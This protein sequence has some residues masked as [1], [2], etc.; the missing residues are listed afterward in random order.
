MTR[1]EAQAAVAACKQ[2]RPEDG[3]VARERDGAWE[4][5][6]LPGMGRK[7]TT[8][9]IRPLDSQLDAATLPRLVSM[10]VRAVL[11]DPGFVSALKF[12]S[13]PVVRLTAG[14]SSLAAILPNS[15]LAVLAQDYRADPTLAAHVALGEL[16]AIWLELPG[17][18]GRGAAVLL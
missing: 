18:A 11:V 10:G 9:L 6:R 5:V 15:E 2:E 3:W 4:V 8:D 7:P 12:Q 13:P 17:T 14:R 1:D 16:A